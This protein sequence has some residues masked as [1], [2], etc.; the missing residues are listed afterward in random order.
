M[1]RVEYNSLCGSDV[2]LYNW[3]PVNMAEQIATIPFTP[4]HETCGIV[5]AIGKNVKANVKI[6]QRVAA[7]THIA[8]ENC[9]Q[10]THDEV[11]LGKSSFVLSSFESL[12]FVSLEETHLP[13]DAS[14]WP[15]LPGRSC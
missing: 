12:L 3:Y 15:Q 14:L 1:I 4:G 7:D 5:V 10:C 6:G 8:C 11:R 9:Y 2:L 13:E